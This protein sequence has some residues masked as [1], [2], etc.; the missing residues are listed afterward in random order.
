MA[1]VILNPK[2]LSQIVKV[3]EENKDY[4]CVRLERQRSKCG[5]ER[6]Q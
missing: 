4:D 5:Y 2:N 3:E 6:R 1:A